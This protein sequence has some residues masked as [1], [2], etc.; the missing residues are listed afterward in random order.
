MLATTFRRTPQAVSAIGSQTRSF[1]GHGI[2]G[3]EYLQ[4]RGPR[5]HTEEDQINFAHW[6]DVNSMNKGNKEK[7][8]VVLPRMWWREQN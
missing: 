6:A 5:L 2:T 8:F 4:P 3:R 1:A 7:N